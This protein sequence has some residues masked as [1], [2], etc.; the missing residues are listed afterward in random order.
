MISDNLRY[1]LGEDKKI[2]VKAIS[3]LDNNS[4]LEAYAPL[5]ATETIKTKE[6]TEETAV[7]KATHRSSDIVT[8]VVVNSFPK[9]SLGEI[10]PKILSCNSPNRKPRQ[11]EANRQA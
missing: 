2:V 9:T 1:E 10:S 4:I 3:V 7:K 6:G 11:A 8:N 5:K